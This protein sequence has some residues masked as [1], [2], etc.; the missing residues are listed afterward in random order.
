M[1]LMHTRS[2]T[3]DRLRACSKTYFAAIFLLTGVAGNVA[4]FMLDDL[5]TVGASGGIFGLLGA[6]AAYF[7]RNRRLAQAAPQ[8][9]LI[10]GLLGL[11]V[12]LGL[13]EGSMVDNTGHVA[14]FV[15]GLWLGWNT[16]PLWE[17]C[18]AVLGPRDCCPAPPRCL[19]VSA[20]LQWSRSSLSP[21]C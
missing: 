11:N 4:S 17:V 20:W 5:V 19:R 12:L 6:L 14:G 8:L 13:D 2:H 21:Q 9:L 7:L 16:C 1:P 10:S 15:S 3:T 18:C